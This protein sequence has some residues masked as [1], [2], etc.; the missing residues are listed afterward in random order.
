MNPG[1]VAALP[2]V[3]VPA[4]LISGRVGALAAGCAGLLATISVLLV[5][6]S[7]DTETRALIG[8]EGLA[9]L[10]LAM[11]AA[12]FIVGGL[13][14]YRCVRA[15]EPG[16]FAAPGQTGDA[17]S[18]GVLDRRRLYAACFLLG[19]FAESATGFG[20]GMIIALPVILNAGA[21]GLTAL[22]FSLFSQMLVAWGSLGV[23][24]A[25]GAELAGVPFADLAERSAWLQ[26][27]VLF[28]HLAVFWLLLAGSGQRPTLAQA[29]DDVVWTG[30]LA[31]G[32]IVATTYIAPELGGLLATG[33]LLVVRALRDEPGV[34]GRAGQVFRSAWP[35]VAL[36]AILVAT[37]VVPP[38]REV[39]Q[40]LWSIR[41]LPQE[42]AFAPLYHPATSLVVIGMAAL[43]ASGRSGALRPV[44]GEV[45]RLGWKPV[46]VTIVYVVLARLIA[47]G[48]LADALAGEATRLVGAGAVYLAPLFGGLSGFLTGSNTA[49][50]GLMMPVQVALA[51][52]AGVDVT[53]AAALQN[54]AGSTLT[55]LS[56]TRI[57]TG[58]ALLGL[59]GQD[60]TAYGRTWVFGAT[61]LAI[62]LI[63]W[64]VVA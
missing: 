52:A 33:G 50:N 16:L 26:A 13:F 8:Q 24:T 14:F 4:L 22:A 59:A 15:S 30:V 51:R 45:W 61:A 18:S 62:L 34:L 35:Y 36:T 54:V 9:G 46:L 2:F 42:V 63:A 43:L 31:I 57:A 3:I 58:C 10:W 49:S 12:A 32:L 6:G 39:L 44:A 28:G 17:S 64:A 41:P 38:V 25:I 53:W 1:L 47:G 40:D 48:G 19:P 20:V 27:P 37:R 29:A 21:R 7:A 11:Q 23:G 56:P 5:L 60:R 55:M